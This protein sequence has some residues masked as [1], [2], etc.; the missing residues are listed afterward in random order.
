M[1]IRCM[2]NPNIIIDLNINLIL[3]YFFKTNI[4]ENVLNLI[5]LPIL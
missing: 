2:L 5:N 1:C 3:I 4:D